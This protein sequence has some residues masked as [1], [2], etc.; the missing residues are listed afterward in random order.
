MLQ[1]ASNISEAAAAFL[2]HA[3]AAESGQAAGST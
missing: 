3:A 1:N 2:Q